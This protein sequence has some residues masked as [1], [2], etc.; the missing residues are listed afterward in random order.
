MILGTLIGLLGFRL[1]PTFGE[2][3]H[4][5]FLLNLFAYGAILTLETTNLHIPREMNFHS[6]YAEFVKFHQV[7][8]PFVLLR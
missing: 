2:K 6:T 1:H 8:G 5:N 4:K 3:F 7:S